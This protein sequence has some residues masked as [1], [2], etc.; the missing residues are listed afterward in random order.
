MNL[1]S[2]ITQ[3]YKN[4][5]NHL[6]DDK[7]FHF[8][9]RM[10]AWYND[11]FSQQYLESVRQDYVK[12][13]ALIREDLAQL[14][15]HPPSAKINAAELRA[16]YFD[17]YPDL[18][19]VMLALFRVRHLHV[20]YGYDA[21]SLLAELYPVEKMYQL[22]DDLQQDHDA[23]KVLST[24]AINFIYLVDEILYPKDGRKIDVE[25][26]YELGQTYD[27]STPEHIQLMI[28]FY[29]HCIIGSSNF[30]MK[31]VNPGHKAIYIAMVDHIER[32]IKKDFDA[33][34]LDNKFEF[35]VCSRIVGRESQLLERIYAEASRSLSFEGTFVV[36]THNDFK[37]SAKT[38]FSD[39]EH[40][41]VLLIMSQATYRD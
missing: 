12:N 25:A 2:D 4:N 14:I 27:L 29:T 38:S 20:I 10:S 31:H 33:V 39:S 34:N 28:Y 30:Y 11:E 5:F 3:Y 9:S 41:N 1:V 8:A 35:L 22:S 36:D 21:R 37:Q 18:R 40:R 17:K 6:S 15:T 32:I 13:K 23:L 16:P 19:G 24:Y 7:K 26:F